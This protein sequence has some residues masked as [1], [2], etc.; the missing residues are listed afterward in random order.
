MAMVGGMRG[1]PPR[2]WL[3]ADSWVHVALS[4]GHGTCEG[5]RGERIGES[6][7]GSSRRTG[8]Q[9]TQEPRSSATQG[10]EVARKGW[11]GTPPVGEPA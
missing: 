9:Q 8:E 6:S 5:R 2:A 7:L 3:P 10:E 4:C 1:A 11:V